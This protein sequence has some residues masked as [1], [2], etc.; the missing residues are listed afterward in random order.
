MNLSYKN[1]QNNTSGN[2][3]YA[4]KKSE[5]YEIYKYFKSINF[6]TMNPLQGDKI[7]DAPQQNIKA[8]YDDKSNSID[9]GTVKDL[10]ENIIRAKKM[11]IDLAS[12]YNQGFK[13]D[14]GLE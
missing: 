13:K 12:K 3:V 6:S 7:L 4:V 1:E 10:P 14:L 11:I 2:G 9:F 8:I 5:S